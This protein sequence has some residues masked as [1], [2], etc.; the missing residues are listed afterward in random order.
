MN[1]IHP[2]SVID[3]SVELGADL[4]IGP[5]CRIGSDVKLGDGCRLI[6]HVVIE[7]PSTIGNENS[8]FPYSY[9]GGEPQDL[10]YNQE[11]TQLIIGSKNTFREGVSV[12]RGTVGG[13]GETVLGD[14]NLLMGYVHVAHDCRIGNHNILANYTGLSGHV[15]MDDH[16]TL[17]GQNGVAQFLRVGSYVYTGAASLIDRN[18]PPYSTGYG[19]RFEVKGVNIVGLKR[20]NFSRESIGE[21]LETHRIYYHAELKNDE[22]LRVIEETFGEST[23][24]RT[25]LDFIYS[26]E[27]SG[28]H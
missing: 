7:G 13:G 8:F 4:E 20:Q 9:I 22:A 12:H 1:N 21:I 23:A 3:D 26:V 16:V 14:E 19:N 28:K 6:S 15:T 2:T 25:F 18:V 17:G 5:Y 10:K 11:K 27:T 24:V